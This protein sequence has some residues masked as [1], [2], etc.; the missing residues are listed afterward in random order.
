MRYQSNETTE[1]SVAW[2]KM[3]NDERKLW[4]YHNFYGSIS[5]TDTAKMAYHISM[6]LIF[7]GD[8]LRAHENLDFGCNM[9]NS[10]DCCDLLKILGG[11]KQTHVE[12][13][14]KIQ[15]FIPV[16]I[17]KI[18]PEMLDL[19]LPIALKLPDDTSQNIENTPSFSIFDMHNEA[20]SQTNQK[21]NDSSIK[22]LTDAELQ[23]I[24]GSKYLRGDG[25]TQDV[26]QAVLWL[27]KA[28]LQGHAKAQKSLAYSYQAGLGNQKD[29]EKSIFWYT[30]AAE[31]DNVEAQYNLAMIYYK[32]IGISQN[33]KKVFYWFNRSAELGFDK[34]QYNLASLYNN[35]DCVDKDQ[36]KSFY[37][38]TKAAKQDNVEAQY[39]VGR[40]CFFGEGT[41]KSLKDCAYWINLAR[42][43]GHKDAEIIWNGEEM[44]K[45]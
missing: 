43:N 19:I 20:L 7:Q 32:G 16:H 31:Q 8:Y 15:K 25:V 39:I 38:F 11:S 30:K 18:T 3:S 17:T 23:Y 14:I 34:A 35:G 29:I 5:I 6:T 26:A 28:A 22:E 1:L 37:W 33:C 45:Y 27:Q 41:K 4:H 40:M 24:E 10:T 21:I 36:N 2:K 13:K 9:L 44:W 42:Q 12:L